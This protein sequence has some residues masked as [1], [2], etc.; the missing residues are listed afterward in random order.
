MNAK[1][2]GQTIVLNINNSEKVV[3]GVH[4]ADTLA[5]VLRDKLGLT[6]TKISCD[7][8]ACG[9]CTVLIDD[10]VH[11]SCITLATLVQGKKIVTV[12]GLAFGDNIDIIQQ[13]Y[14][15]ER[16]FACGYC[17]SGFIM[18]TKAL[19]KE[20]PNPTRQQ[21]KEAISGNICRCGV[22]EHIENAIELAAKRIR[23]VE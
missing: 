20:N 5:D 4:E 9:S 2:L 16:G 23:E 12:E 11:L 18:T 7:E 13:A 1:N 17:T 15:D 14:L 3:Y 21:I 8:G 6:G 22:Y 19:L 10:K